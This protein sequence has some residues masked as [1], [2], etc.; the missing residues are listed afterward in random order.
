MFES[1]T[2]SLQSRITVMPNVAFRD[3]SSQQGNM[4]RACVVHSCVTAEYDVTG[5]FPSRASLYPNHQ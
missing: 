4:Q 1:A 3:G 2:K 5:S